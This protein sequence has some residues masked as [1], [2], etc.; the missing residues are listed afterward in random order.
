MASGRATVLALGL[1]VVSRRRALL[2]AAGAELWSCDRK[3]AHTID[4]MR[5]HGTLRVMRI[6]LEL[7]GDAETSLRELE[8]RA[9]RGV[10]RTEIVSEA[11][12]EAWLRAQVE[13]T[14]ERGDDESDPLP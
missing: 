1:A 2:E 7:R 10:T 13:E 4:T 14:R 11:I 8:K 6:T 9:A 12:C 5:A 3:D